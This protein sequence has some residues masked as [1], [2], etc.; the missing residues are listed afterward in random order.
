MTQCSHY[1]LHEYI[2]LTVLPFADDYGLNLTVILLNEPPS[3]NSRSCSIDSNYDEE[4]QGDYLF[5]IGNVTFIPIPELN[6]NYSQVEYYYSY[7]FDGPSSQE[8]VS[9]VQ[10]YL[11][12]QYTEIGYYNFTIHAVAFINEDL[13]HH[14]EYSGYFNIFGKQEVRYN[15]PFKKN[16]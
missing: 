6:S 3:S 8:K 16:E 1:S 9:S 5:A 13:A 4:Q 7:F 12:R 10:K 15:I 11:T 14:A 2:I